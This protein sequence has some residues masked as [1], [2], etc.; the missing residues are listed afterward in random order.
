M[1]EEPNSPYPSILFYLLKHSFIYRDIISKLRQHYPV[2]SLTSFYT[3]NIRNAF[4]PLPQRAKAPCP[5]PSPIST[6]SPGSSL[7][8]E[9][10]TEVTL[11]PV[12]TRKVSPPL[13][14]LRRVNKRVTD[15]KPFHCVPT[16]SVVPLGG[17]WLLT[18]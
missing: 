5:L 12:A 13:W 7:R 2:G 17:C 1:H 8:T 18:Q 9:H 14:G 16:I 4:F 15:P 6:R 11:V 10:P 3:F